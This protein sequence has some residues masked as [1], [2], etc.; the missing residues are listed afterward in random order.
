MMRAD[1]DIIMVGEIRDRET[2]QI[3]VESALTGH[4]VL[5]TL[6][7]NDAPTAITRLTEM[8]IEPFLVASAIDC[9][10]AQ[11]LAR[12]LCKHCKQRDDPH[13]PRSCASN[14]FAA[15]VDIEAF[16]PGGCSRCSGSGYKGRLGLYE[17]MTVTE[18]IRT[19]TIERASADRIA[20]VAVRDGMRRLRQ[21]G[22]EKVKLGRTSIAEVARVT[23]TGARRRVTR[24][25]RQ[26]RAP[27][28]KDRA[29][30][31]DRSRVM[32]FDFADVLLEVLERKASDLHITV[33]TPPM[34]RVRGRLTPMEGYSKLSPTD[35]REIIYSIL[36]NDQRQRLETDWQIDFAYAIPGHARFRVNAYF[37]RGSLGAAFRL[38]P[39]E[40]L[41]DRRPGPAARH[42]T[43]SARS[44]AASCSSPARPARASPRR[45]PR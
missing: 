32:D 18:E 1:P 36:S 22:F 5:S 40:I 24:R 28:L 23:G 27:G 17:V 42:R 29:Q 35:T 43:S 7:T 12:T 9:V 45:S 10:V 4:L 31:T 16:E 44:R 2:A 37:Q 38:I 8:G 21:D 13:R 33:G 25:S 20:E 39:A 26:F 30:R 19:L 3:A 14:G 41:L 34:V 6:H 15:H 11:R